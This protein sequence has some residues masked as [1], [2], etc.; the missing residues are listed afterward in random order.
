M[1]LRSV[2][3]ILFAVLFVARGAH[4]DVGDEEENYDPGPAS[5]RSSF[6]AGLTFSTLVGGVQGYPNKVE[7]IGVPEYHASTGVAGGA[8]G[9]FWLGAALRDWLVLGAGA[10]FGTI[11][12]ANATESNGGAFVLHAEAFPLFYSSETL[13][14]FAIVG[15]FGAGSRDVWN[16]SVKKADGGATSYASVGVLFEPFRVGRHI[17]AGPIVQFAYQFS[18]NLTA[19][20]ASLGIQL[21]YYGGP[22]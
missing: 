13:R 5:R 6:A 7:Q 21:S 10:S 22:G 3:P 16:G 11:A 12:G 15:E 20:L 14:D 19:T 2:L 1:T 9:G 17:S 18:Q 4:A 8:G